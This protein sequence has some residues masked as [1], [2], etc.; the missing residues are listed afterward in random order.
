VD[1][2]PKIQVIVTAPP[3]ANFLNEISRHPLVTGFRLNTVMPLRTGP[4][5]VIKR[6][7]RYHQPLWIDLKGR[8]LRV[9]GAAI[10]PFT[11]VRISHTIRVNTPAEAF[12]SDGKETAT[13]VA[14]DG[15][16]LIF[17]DQPRR[18]IGPGESINI[19]DPS[20]E[21]DGYL[22]DL[23]QAYLEA[24]NKQGLNRVILS[25][26]EG[27]E[28]L[29]EVKSIIPDANMLLK[30]ETSKGLDFIEKYGQR[31]GRLVAARGDLFIEV[32]RPHHIIDAV[33]KIIRIDRNA[34]VA[35]RILDS[36]ATDQIPISADISDVAFL[37][38][39]GY[40]TFLL[41]DAICLQRDS[42]IEALNLLEAIAEDF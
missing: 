27:L 23:D 34:I 14:V 22:T 31:D 1:S 29:I 5:E 2:K 3:Y 9:V 24:M 36:L 19:I 28:D 10:P 12:F 20:L 38:E 32:K 42:L 21:I 18:L 40:R 30:I 26:V 25:Y 17:E 35:S 4:E 15:D 33:R 13:I 6:L 7:T 16:R 37:L 39:I 11:D 41:G 8:Q